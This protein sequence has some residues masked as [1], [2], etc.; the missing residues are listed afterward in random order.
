MHGLGV[1]PIFFM[2]LPHASFLWAPDI[3]RGLAQKSRWNRSH[4]KWLSTHIGGHL[5]LGP[6]KVDLAILDLAG[7]KIPPPPCFHAFFQEETIVSSAYFELQF[8]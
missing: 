4:R 3:R 7:H 5:D 6:N 8:S 2:F 1:L